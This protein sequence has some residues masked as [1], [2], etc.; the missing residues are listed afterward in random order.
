MERGQWTKSLRVFS[1]NLMDKLIRRPASIIISDPRNGSQN[2]FQ[3]VREKLIKKK[4]AAFV[5]WKEDVLKVIQ[6]SRG[7]EDPLVIN[8]CD[9]FEAHFLKEFAVLQELSE[10]RLKNALTRVADELEKLM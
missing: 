9:D 7:S 1:L 8:V 5:D 3:G 10:F 2:T 6:S 4:Y